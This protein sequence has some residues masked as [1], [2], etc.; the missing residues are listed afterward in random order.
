MPATKKTTKTKTP[1]KTEVKPVVKPEINI[2]VEEEKPGKIEVFIP[3]ETVNVPKDDETVDE[4]VAAFEEE[5][6]N[7]KEKYFQSVG[8]RKNSI[9]RIRLYTKKSTDVIKE[10][11]ALIIVNNKDYYDYFTDSNLRLVVESPLRKLKSLN[12]FKA[13]IVT[14]GG[15]LSGQASAI[16]HGLT[17]ALVLFDINFKKKLKK[18][19][20]LTRDSRIKERR[21][22]GLKKARKAPQWAKR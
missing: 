10:D 1:K 21:K 3:E 11:K 19:G 14:H 2:Q 8:R 22:P 7:G 16:R 20:F 18:A 6:K 5:Q 9:A 15:G 13:S 12:R 4:S 17:R